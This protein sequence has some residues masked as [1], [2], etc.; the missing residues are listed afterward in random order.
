MIDCLAME[1]MWASYI[2]CEATLTATVRGSHN[3]HTVVL[4]QTPT[5]FSAVAEYAP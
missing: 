3:T 4:Q 2:A 5:I 1:D